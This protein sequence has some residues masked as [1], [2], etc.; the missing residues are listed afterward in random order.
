MVDI[1]AGGGWW[2]E[3][4]ARAVGAQGKVHA[5]EVDEEKV[6]RLKEKF[7]ETPQVRSYLCEK[8]STTLSGNSCD[9]AFLSQ[10]FHHLEKEGRVEY[11]RHLTGILKPTGR[12]VIIERYPGISGPGRSHGTNVSALARQAEES[13]ANEASHEVARRSEHGRDNDLAVKAP[14]KSGKKSKT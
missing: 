1:G 8:N 11:L 12:L 4:F 5:A 14:K 6:E 7:K 10:T 3:H 9:L 13:A 2:S